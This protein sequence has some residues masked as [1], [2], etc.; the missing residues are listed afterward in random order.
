MENQHSSVL[1]T[2]I[3]PVFNNIRDIESCLQ[4]VA[5]QTYTF[6]EHWIIDGGSTD[7]TLEIIQQYAL[8]YPHIKW[9]SEKDNGIYDAINKGLEKAIGDW[10]YV[11]G[12]DDKLKIETVIEEVLKNTDNQEFDVL[13]GNIMLRETGEVLGECT[14]IDG[15]KYTCTHHQATFTRKSVFEK[16]GKYNEKYPICADW[17]FTI[18]CF[19]TKDIKLK[20]IDSIVAIYSMNGFSNLS[21]GTNIRIKDKAFNKDFF[22]LFEKFS[23][24]DKLI[25][26]SNDYLPKYL[27]PLRYLGFL[28]K[29]LKTGFKYK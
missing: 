12:S 15:L 24:K 2:I 18:K 29:H 23:F 19:R 22:Q 25:I 10:I 5:Q 11:L 4:S 1:L 17:A 9:I 6:K 8:Q 7:G 16:L 27:N 3:T 20:Y 14:N 21:N 13:Y 28:K 26:Y